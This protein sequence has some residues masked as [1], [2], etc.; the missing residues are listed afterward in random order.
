MSKTTP[1]KAAKRPAKKTT[2]AKTTR[3]SSARKAQLAAEATAKKEKKFSRT[4]ILVIVSVVAVAI[5]AI[6]AILVAQAVQQKQQEAAEA[7]A[8]EETQAKID[9]CVSETKKSA[10]GFISECYEE[11]GQEVPDEVAE[12]DRERADRIIAQQENDKCRALASLSYQSVWDMNDDSPYDGV[13]D[14]TRYSYSVEFESSYEDDLDECD[15]QNPLKDDYESR[16]ETEIKFDLIGWT[17][18]GDMIVDVYV[19][20][21][22]YTMKNINWEDLD[23]TY[24]TTSGKIAEAFKEEHLEFWY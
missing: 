10:L 5:A 4:L 1:K 3:Q 23:F 7:K 21:G 14:T 19:D 11:Q 8:A 12:K 13:L 9:E 24:V 15:Q 18:D 16:Y 22:D 6:A 2:A 17:S 20:Y